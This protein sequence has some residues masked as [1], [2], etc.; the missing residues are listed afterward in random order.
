M[1]R[2]YRWSS[3][4]RASFLTGPHMVMFLHIHLSTY[5]YILLGISKNEM[6]A[7]AIRASPATHAVNI[8]D[9]VN[10]VLSQ[11]LSHLQLS[12][13][14]R[15]LFG[16]NGH[17]AFWIMPLHFCFAWLGWSTG[18]MQIMSDRGASR[19]ASLWAWQGIPYGMIDCV[20]LA[21]ERGH[22]NSLSLQPDR[23]RT[24]R[25]DLQGWNEAWKCPSHAQ[26]TFLPQLSPILRSS[27]P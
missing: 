8:V 16:L 12:F 11:E 14:S 27:I 9:F 1:Q 5:C 15:C 7:S 22:L 21:W 2:G 20:T 26:H 17:S 4:C 6:M 19:P 3:C 18:S 10:I 13:L 25:R 24:N 23:V